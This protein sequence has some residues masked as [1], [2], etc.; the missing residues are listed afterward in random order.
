MRLT[1]FFD[2]LL[3]TE[4]LDAHRVWAEEGGDELLSLLR[5]AAGK[6]GLDHA[7]P[8]AWLDGDLKYR[9]ALAHAW[10]RRTC[11]SVPVIGL[12]PESEP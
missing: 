12:C 10:Y 11:R 4:F 7:Q 8:P 6:V 5:F 2:R 9:W 3:V 1:T